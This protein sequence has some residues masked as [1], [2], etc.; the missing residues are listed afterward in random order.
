MT[1]AENDWM[2]VIR[3]GGEKVEGKGRVKRRKDFPFQK[4]CSMYG[5]VEAF[6]WMQV[7]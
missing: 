4:F 1:T 5:R 3:W 2:M 7:H 6:V